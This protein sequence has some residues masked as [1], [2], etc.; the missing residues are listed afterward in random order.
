MGQDFSGFDLQKT[1]D[2]YKTL[3]LIPISCVI[4]IAA[5]L[6]KQSQKSAAL[7]AGVLPFFAAGYWLYQLGAQIFINIL[8][9]GAYF[10][11]CLGLVLIVLSS[12]SK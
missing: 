12:R 3:W 1:G 4:T 7:F 2:Y 10:G 8:G 11:L 6:A 9:I 5:G